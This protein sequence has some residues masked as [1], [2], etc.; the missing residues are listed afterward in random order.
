MNGPTY[1][2]AVGGTVMKMFDT[3]ADAQT[4]GETFPG[5]VISKEYAGRF[6]PIAKWTGTSWQYTHYTAKQ[7]AGGRIAKKKAKR[8]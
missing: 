7:K 2:V 5:A 6:L 3:V 1:S 8:R 4:F